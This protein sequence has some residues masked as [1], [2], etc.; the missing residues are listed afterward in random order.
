M[1]NSEYSI[2]FEHA[3]GAVDMTKSKICSGLYKFCFT[4]LYCYSAIKLFVIC[5]NVDLS[6]YS[7]TLN[8]SL[9]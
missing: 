2:Q 7:R 8:I 9:H 1:N 5:E 6:T 3:V 4:L